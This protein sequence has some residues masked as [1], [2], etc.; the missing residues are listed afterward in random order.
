M[1]FLRLLANDRQHV[2][3]GRMVYNTLYIEYTT[4]RLKSTID[5]LRRGEA[6][7][8]VINDCSLLGVE[9]YKSAFMPHGVLM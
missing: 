5:E 8:S 3:F 7:Y 6:S 2:V 1:S 9:P 4:I